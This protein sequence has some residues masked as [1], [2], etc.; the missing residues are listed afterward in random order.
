MCRNSIS[1]I[2]PVSVGVFVFKFPEVIYDAHWNI[3]F[4]LG[5]FLFV[6]VVVQ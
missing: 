2:E 5:F 4:I 3:A 1:K 6:V